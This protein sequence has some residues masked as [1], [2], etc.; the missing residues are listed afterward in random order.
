[1][2][3]RDFSKRVAALI[4]THPSGSLLRTIPEGAISVEP[5]REELSANPRA[6][7]EFPPGSY[8]PYG[9]LDNPYHCWA[10]HQSGVLRSVLPIGFAWYYPAGPGGYFYYK[11]DY[12]YWT[13]LRLGILFEGKTYFEPDDFGQAGVAL[14]SCYHSKN[15]FTFDFTIGALDFACSFFLIGEDTLAC[16]LAVKNKGDGQQQIELV[17]CQH[18]QFG[19]PEWWGRDGI[20]ASYDETNDQTVLRSFAAGPVFAL[21]SSLPAS[22]HTVTVDDTALLRWMRAGQAGD[23]SATSYFPKPMNAGLSLAMQVPAA[24]SAQCSFYLTRG[25]DQRLVTRN[26]LQSRQQAPSV[27]ISKRAE[28]GTFWNRAP[29]L[30][31][32][33]PD[34]WKNGWVYDFETLRMMVRRPIGLYKHPWDA[35]QIQAPRNVLAETSIDMWA[36]AYADPDSAKAVL[37]GQFQDA[38]EPNV[39]CMREDGTMNMVAADGSECGTAL[40]WCYPFYCIESVFLRTGDR[41]W[42]AALYP[43][44]KK[45]LEWTL[46]H[47]RDRDGWITAKCS[48]ETGMDANSRFLIKQPTGGEVIDFIRVA[49]LQAAMAHAARMLTGW[50]EILSHQTDAPRWK[51]LEM[52]YTEKTRQLFRDGWFCDVDARSGQ[53]IAGQ[54]VVTQ[55]GPVMCG[56]ATTEQIRAMIP[57]ML[58]YA[59]HQEDSLDWPSQVLPYAESMWSAGQRGPVS[60]ILY[61]IVDRVYRSTDRRKIDPKQ[62]LGWPGVSREMWSVAEGAGGG[63]CYGWGATLP[64]H[65]I[66]SIFGLRESRDRTALQFN[67][68][69][70][71]PDKLVEMGKT[72]GLRNVQY[73]RFSFGLRYEI[74]GQDDLEVQILTGRSAAPRAIRVASLAGGTVEVNAISG[75][76][77]FKA[78]N[79]AA[80]SVAL[81]V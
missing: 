52:I 66:R 33:F 18:L 76:W 43:Y 17:A 26:S 78:K 21:A 38:L 72:F 19:S 51:Q 8:T 77:S 57:N 63:E 68:G 3:R 80:Y 49:E 64:A 29:F 70:N 2:N 79:H 16:D 45:Y 54:R 48:W 44:L 35:M 59:T 37:L 75:G 25:V 60:D 4:A 47:R 55:V 5:S 14:S 13:S 62:Q 56:T 22:K 31:G 34:H 12:I 32:D 71:L 7:G 61:G 46:Q 74:A 27:L 6:E 42:A 39:P 28:D 41:E 73:R 67:L 53:P 10:L 30:E 24:G 36:F 40:Q 11:E 23:S 20:A 1:V 81:E 65:I 58:W 15:I 50:A 9:Y 69:P